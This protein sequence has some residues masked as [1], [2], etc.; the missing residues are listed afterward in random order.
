MKTK[1][2]HQ[3]L[4]K[5][6]AQEGQPGLIQKQS[7]DQNKTEQNHFSVLHYNI[8]SIKNKLSEF[9][10]FLD[11][12]KEPLSVLCISEH[13]ANS[14]EKIGL[15][16]ANY[17]L[18]SCYCREQFVHGGVLVY[19]R[20]NLEF[21]EITNLTTKVLEI[22][23]EYACAINKKIKTIIICVYRS[24]VEGKC[25]TFFDLF[26]ELLHELH[27]R[28]PSYNYVIC[29]DLNIDF[30]KDDSHKTNLVNILKMFDLTST[31]KSATR[32]R[33]SSATQI[34]YIITNI[35]TEY[36]T[37]ILELGMSDHTA[38]IISFNNLNDIKYNKVK[39][40]KRI[41]N[42]K[43]KQKFSNLLNNIDWTELYAKQ[44]INEA[45]DF[46]QYNIKKCYDLACP[47]RYIKTQDKVN[48]PWITSG[49]KI[50]CKNKRFLIEI[51]NY[52]EDVTILHYIKAYCKILKQLINISKQ[53]YFNN[54]IRQ[55]DNKIKTTWNCINKNINKKQEQKMEKI[56]LK[57]SDNITIDDT[58]MVAHSFQEYFIEEPIKLTNNLNPTKN[59]NNYLKNCPFSSLNSF[60]FHPVVEQDIVRVVNKLKIKETVG[61]DEIPIT[62]IKE[63]IDSLKTPLTFIINLSLTTGTFPDSL[64]I[65]KIV[66]IYK[67]GKKQTYQIID[68]YQFSPHLQKLLN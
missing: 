48:T 65:A 14:Q 1:H 39:I 31:L 62:R 3:L 23:F 11:E 17:N 49:I 36:N 26:W 38:Q 10:I 19:A 43:S 44:D 18:I 45:Y 60:H 33:K 51:K 53:N 32:I 58:S 22:E 57:T 28:Y 59:P 34:D 29:G 9:E 4:F 21:S 63:N 66:P 61:F 50:S 2:L 13:W 15:K 6:Q 35:K 40:F 27:N 5:P 64:K 67:K 8:Q 30:Q 46:F 16:I 68:Q 25:D 56:I 42:E 47:S 55:S 37:S 54:A 7:R 52:T 12:L 20:N 24:S 41:V